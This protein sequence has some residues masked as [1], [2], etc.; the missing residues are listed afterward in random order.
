[1]F[2][3]Q[4]I[5]SPNWYFELSPAHKLGKE[6]QWLWAVRI[7]IT[8]HCIHSFLQNKTTRWS[9]FWSLMPFTFWQ[10]PFILVPYRTESMRSV[11]HWRYYVPSK[12]RSFTSRLNVSFAELVPTFLLC[13]KKSWIFFSLDAF[14]SP[15]TLVISLAMSYFQEYKHGGISRK[16]C[17]SVLN[18]SQNSF[19]FFFH[20]FD[21]CGVAHFWLLV[22]NIH[23]VHRVHTAL[24]SSPTNQ[25]QKY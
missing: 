24:A 18:K 15:F 8:V 7:C 10:H 23:R 21:V 11:C 16:P 1:M 20:F 5:L 14:I 4:Q 19:P 22:T 2:L 3:L 12:R 25:T 13:A 17:L 9:R 6:N